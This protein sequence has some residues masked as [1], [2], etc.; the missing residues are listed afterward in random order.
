MSFDKKIESFL[1]LGKNKTSISV[2]IEKNKLIFKKDFFIKKNF[3]DLNQDVYEFIEKS[4]LEFE[5]K[6]QIFLKQLNVIID[7]DHFFEINVSKKEKINKQLITKE[8]IE[9]LIFDLK[10]LVQDNNS[11]FSITTIKIRN[12]RIDE[13]NYKT[14]ENNK[15]GDTLSL[16]VT[17]ES[18]KKDLQIKIKNF[19][20]SLEVDI[21]KYLSTNYFETDLPNEK[22]DECALAAKLHYD[23]DQ[24]EVFLVKKNKENI[25]FFE[26]FFQLLSD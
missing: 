7:Y 1:Y 15:S 12:F 3:L 19:L 5:S 9:F 20:S 22:M 6:N 11:D 18:I 21:S 25:S 16:E 23:Y 26:K 24:N 13:K 4:I 8:D 14:F 17:F 10:K 2:Y